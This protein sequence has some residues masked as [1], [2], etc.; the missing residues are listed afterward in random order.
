MIRSHM[1]AE[2]QPRPR[3]LVDPETPV[4]ETPVGAPTMELV[5]AQY[6]RYVATIGFRILG[7]GSDLDDLFQDV[8]LEAHRNLHT[9]KD[10]DALRPWLATVTVRAARR[11]L[12]LRQLA[13]TFLPL[14][15]VASFDP[16]D[17]NTSADEMLLY[18]RLYRALDR[19]PANHRIA[20]TLQVM[21]GESL[22]HIAEIC[23]GSVAAVKRWIGKAQDV[24]NRELGQ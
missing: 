10:W 9:L 5:V 20:W 23:G 7:R 8:F 19:L 18:G 17:P 22:Q 6:S 2:R 13:R 21:Q 11:M 1:A 16:V 15:S 3:P 4:G 24:V 14:A 12:R